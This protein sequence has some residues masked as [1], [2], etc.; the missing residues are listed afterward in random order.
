MSFEELG[1]TA[2]LLRAAEGLGFVVPTAI[3]AA[4]IPVLI[5]DGTDV[6]GQAQTG[7][8]KTAAFGFPLLQRIDAFRRRPQAVVLC[9]TRELCLQITDDFSKYAKHMSAV[10]CAAVYGGASIADQIRLLKAGAQ[11]IVATPGRLLDLIQR[12]AVDVR[13][14]SLVVLDEADEMLNMGF[15]EELDGI[16]TQLPAPRRTWL[17]SATMPPG[18]A[19]IAGAYLSAPVTI[20]GSESRRNLQTISHTCHVVAHPNRYKALKRLI[21]FTPDMFALVF[22]RT[23]KDTQAVAD[24]L[25]T[26]GCPAAALHGDL[27]QGQRDAVMRQF[28]QASVRVLVATD[29]AAR[30]LDVDDITHVIHYHLPGDAETYTHRSGRTARAGKTGASVVI[31]SRN[32]MGRVKLLEKQG[33]IQFS[34]EKLPDGNAVCR[35]QI[36]ALAARIHAAGETSEVVEAFMPAVREAFADLDRDDLMRALVSGEIRRVLT[37]TKNAEDINASARPVSKVASVKQRLKGA[38]TQRFIINVGTMDRINEGAILRLICEQAGIRS[39]RVGAIDLKPSHCVVEIDKRAAG[40]VKKGIRDV[41]LDGRPVSLREFYE[42]KPTVKTKAWEK[43]R[44][45]AKAKGRTASPYR[46]QGKAAA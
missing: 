17:F 7:T 10:R 34:V 8:G 28:R 37:D 39:D 43:A 46:R 33:K 35:R 25:I 42:G 29:V 5:E 9:P 38:P 40:S 2:A 4:A 26:D 20:A 13:G 36:E 24:A 27:S 22:C 16:L 32:E 31:V 12:R 14:V 1:L 15:K 11:V 30:G 21:D 19:A 41:M 45:A 6:I 23:R 3:Q 44:P 18:V